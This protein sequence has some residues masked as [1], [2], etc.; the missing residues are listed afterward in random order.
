VAVKGKVSND[1]A[2]VDECNIGTERN[3]K[4]VKLSSNS[5]KEQRADYTELLRE[6]SDVFS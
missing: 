3:P 1:D 4:F 6:F 2:D 5:S